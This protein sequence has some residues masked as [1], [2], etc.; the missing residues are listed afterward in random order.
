VKL[1]TVVVTEIEAVL[2]D[3]E[4]TSV[5]K[6]LNSRITVDRRAVRLV[7]ALRGLQN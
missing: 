6:K 2:T 1:R 7:R 3:A 4:A 5:L